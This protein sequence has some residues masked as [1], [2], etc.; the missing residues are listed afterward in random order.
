MLQSGTF[1]AAECSCS[2]IPR[3]I[4][5]H[6]KSEEDGRMGS[7]KLGEKQAHAGIINLL[8]KVDVVLFNESFSATWRLGA[9]R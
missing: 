4:F 6:D 1:V 3:L 8:H 7:G 9:L 5:T 2:A